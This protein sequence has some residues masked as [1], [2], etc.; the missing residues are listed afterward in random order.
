MTVLVGFLAF[1]AIQAAGGQATESTNRLLNYVRGERTASDEAR[2][3]LLRK[4]WHL[5]VEHPA[6]G[7]GLGKYE[8]TYHPVVEDTS[9]RVARSIA[10]RFE[11]HNTFAAV[12]AETGFIG[13]LL[14][15]GL[16]TSLLAMGIRLRQH[17]SVRA[18]TVS[19]VAL[20]FAAFFHNVSGPRLF[21]PV[22]LLLAAVAS[23]VTQR[24][25]GTGK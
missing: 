16:C 2:E 11:E 8:E 12:M 14:L 24:A 21:I 18:A 25:S 10:L 3:L 23:S 5:A 19:F 15:V 9:N 6:F 13:L 7:V 20:I 17:R 22:A 1:S 4:A